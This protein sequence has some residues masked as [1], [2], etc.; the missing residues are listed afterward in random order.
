M[1]D[2]QRKVREYE[3]FLND[4]LR[5][6]LQRAWSERDRLFS[7]QAEYERLRVTITTLDQMYQ[8]HKGDDPLRTQ[9]DLGCSF[10]VQAECP[11]NN[12]IFISIGFGLFCELTYDE[13]REFI[14]KKIPHLREQQQELSKKIAHIKA[15]IKLV[16]EAL[17]EIQMIDVKK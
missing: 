11:V 17:K 15:N 16:L 7:E 1:T 6:D 8:T 9:M 14:E 5:S 4:R 12:R 10:F 2:I 3:T 13:A